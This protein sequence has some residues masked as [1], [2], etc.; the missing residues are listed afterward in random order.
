MAE[1]KIVKINLRK[2]MENIPRWRRQAVFGR[3]LRKKLKN[4]KMKISQSLNEKIWST[5]SPKVRVRIVKDD[6]SVKA[7]LV[8]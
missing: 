5:K 6:K 1:E 4:E 8:E 2:Q 3:L 7:E